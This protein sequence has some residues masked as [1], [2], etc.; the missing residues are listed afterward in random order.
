MRVTHPGMDVFTGIE[1]GP[2]T[3][4]DEDQDLDNEGVDLNIP[5]AQD[6]QE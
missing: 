2:D 5:D 1:D 6:S 3:E 4:D